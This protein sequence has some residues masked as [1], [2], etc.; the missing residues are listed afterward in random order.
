MV[1][2]KRSLYFF[3]PSRF[4]LFSIPELYKYFSTTFTRSTLLKLAIMPKITVKNMHG[5]VAET[6]VRGQS[7]LEVI[8]VEPCRLDACLWG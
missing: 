7:V 1:L 6:T 2:V 8:A 5:L 3:I 4:N